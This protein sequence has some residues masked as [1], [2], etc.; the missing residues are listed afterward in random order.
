MVRLK[1]RKKKAYKKKGRDWPKTLAQVGS[2]ASA[3]FSIAS[4]VASMVN[5]EDKYKD[6]TFNASLSTAASAQVVGNGIPQG[7]DNTQRVGRQIRLK[8]FH[9]RA[10]FTMNSA[11]TTQQLVYY[12]LIDKKHDSSGSFFNPTSYLTVADEISFRNI[13]FHKRFHT[14]K[15]RCL[16]FAIN[17][18]NRNHCI[19]EYIDLSN[20]GALA[21]TEYDG[22]GNLLSDISAFPIYVLVVTSAAVGQEIDLRSTVRV[23]YVD[24]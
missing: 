14:I 4:T 19:D 7:T 1:R 5:S 18:N 21:R 2:V 12:I 15:R 9:W 24:N 11:A 22:T 8:A 10:V 17:G 3:A 20:M 13:D 23:R 16:R 6:T